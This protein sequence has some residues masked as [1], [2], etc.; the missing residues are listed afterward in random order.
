MISLY[1]HGHVTRLRRDCLPGRGGG[2]GGILLRMA[3]AKGRFTSS[4]SAAHG[5]SRAGHT[6]L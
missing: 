6:L 4:S 3:R 5:C 1:L 2:G